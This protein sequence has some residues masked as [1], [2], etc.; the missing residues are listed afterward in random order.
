MMVSVM[1]N[2]FKDIIEASMTSTPEEITD[3]RTILPM[4]QPTVKKPSASKSLR[5]S[6]NIFDV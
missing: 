4:T 1:T 2:F 5:F 3:E 6:T